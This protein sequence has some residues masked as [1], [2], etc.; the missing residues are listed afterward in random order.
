MNLQTLKNLPR[1]IWLIIVAAATV[2]LCS[3]IIHFLSGS[4]YR[5]GNDP[6]LP[7]IIR[8]AGDETSLYGQIAAKEA[9]IAAQNAIAA[10]LSERQTLLDSMKADIEAAR[11]RVPPNAQKGDVRQ[12][13][14]ALGRQVGSSPGDLEVRSFAVREAAAST[15][16]SAASDY[17]SVEY[18]T[19]VTGD[20][21]GIIQFINLIE[22]NERFM[23]VE[24]I[25]LTTGGVAFNSETN[26]VEPKPHT[27]QLRIVTYIDSTGTP[28]ATRRN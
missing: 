16:R 28:P 24:G 9:A 25:Q 6:G 5:L 15:S 4:L 1:K 18:Q 27:A 2:L 14:E 22:R 3:V 13:F 26:K 20:M 19:S 7:G 17:S 8:R 23:T 11:K 12:L 21:D 10:K